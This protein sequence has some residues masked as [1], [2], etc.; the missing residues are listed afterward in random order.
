MATVSVTLVFLDRMQSWTGSRA[1]PV[2]FGQVEEFTREAHRRFHF[3]LHFD[4]GRAL[5][6]RR[7]CVIGV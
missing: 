5:P 1:R 6:W 7:G 4:L 3:E 2:D